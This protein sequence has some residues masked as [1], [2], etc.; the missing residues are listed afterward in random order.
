MTRDEPLGDGSAWRQ[1]HERRIIARLAGIEGVRC[2]LGEQ[3]DAIARGDCGGQTLAQI[4]TVGPLPVPALLELALHMAHTLAEIHRRGVLHQNISPENILVHGS[5]R[6]PVLIDFHLAATFA[7]ENPAF[8]HHREIRGNLAYLAPEQT[9]RTGRSVDLRS[10]L[11][12]LG[13]TLYESATGRPPFEAKDPLDLLHD[14]LARLPVPPVQLRED[15]P[16]ALSQIIMRLLEKEPVRRYQSA[17]GLAYDLTQIRRRLDGGDTRPVCLGEMDFPLR[18]SAPSRLAGRDR[19]IEVLRQTLGD[20][21]YGQGRIVLVSGAPGVGKTSL[22]N[23]LRTMVTARRGWFVSGK[24]DQYR[25]D[26]HTAP[27]QALRALGR[28]LLAEP[29]AELASQRER[30]IH[31]LGSSAAADVQPAGVCAAVWPATRSPCR[32]AGPSRGQAAGDGGGPA[33]RHCLAR[34][35]HCHGPGRSAMGRRGVGSFHRRRASRPGPAGLSACGLIPRRRSGCGAPGWPRRCRVGITLPRAPLQLRLE[36]LP[37]TDLQEMLQE[38]MRLPPSQ[39]ADLARAVDK[40]TEGN[41][42]DTVELLN[43]LR[44][45]GALRSGPGGWEWDAATLRRYVGHSGVV[46]L[47]AARVA[48]L[49]PSGQTLMHAMAC[50]GTEVRLDL[51]SV[52]CG[53]SADALDEQL[54]APL[55]DGLLVIEPGEQD[56]SVRMRHDRVQQAVYSTL[57]PARRGALHLGMARRLGASRHYTTAAAEQYLSAVQDMDEPEECANVA[58]LLHKVAM[59]SRS[60][61]NYAAMQRLLAGALSLLERLPFPTADDESLRNAL[62]VDLHMALCTLGQFEEADALYRVIEARSAVEDWIQAGCEQIGSL[63]N[64]SR[65]REA[66][67]LGLSLLQQLGLRVPDDFGVVDL[68]QRLANLA[69]GSNRLTSGRIRGPTPAIDVQWLRQA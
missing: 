20:A 36:N 25:R 69:T 51:L 26:T 4:L 39:A 13:A 41:P 50:I 5:Q 44:G 23:E 31:A 3:S 58:R 32:G 46:D 12:A 30:I 6:L 11:Y 43:A 21:V 37:C 8:T 53:M 54:A 29:D 59:L 16:V 34:T 35:T 2:L 61:A 42:F 45:D 14:H 18:L 64:R 27:V 28:F 40:H 55:E 17:E 10:D 49:P 65:S 24:F 22:I 15:L 56:S 38:M 60:T 52:A 57:E 47:L 9:G 68:E 19:E 7:E 63:Q 67:A 1:S 48:R 62:Q 66:V 33:A